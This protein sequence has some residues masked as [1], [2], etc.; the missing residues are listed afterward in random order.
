MRLWPWKTANPF[1][2]ASSPD[3]AF[4]TF[5]YRTS[6]AASAPSAVIWATTSTV[7]PLRSSFR[8]ALRTGVL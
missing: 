7:V 3:G 5:A 4:C 8:L 2:S 6:T 1:T